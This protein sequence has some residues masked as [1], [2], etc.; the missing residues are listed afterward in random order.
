MYADFIYAQHYMGCGYPNVDI[1][2]VNYICAI[3]V[4]LAFNHINIML[5]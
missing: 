2:Y 3:L 5:T 4:L 1:N